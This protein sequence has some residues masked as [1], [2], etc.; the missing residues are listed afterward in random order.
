M[1]RTDLRIC[2][3]EVRVMTTRSMLICPRNIVTYY[4]D[5]IRNEERAKKIVQAQRARKNR[6]IPLVAEEVAK[7]EYVLIENF[8]YYSALLKAQPEVRVPCLVY[9]GTCEEERLIHIL[10]ISIPLDK[11]T[12]WLFKNEHVMKLKQDHELSEREI[13]R[14]AKFNTATINQYILDTRIPPHI[15]EKAFEM[16]AK[17][18]LEKICS[19]K[20]VPLEVKMIL[21]E[22][23]IIEQGND[24]R[25]TGKKFDYMKV[26]CSACNLPPSLLKDTTELESLINKLLSSNFE[27]SDHRVSLLNKFV[28]YDT[29]AYQS[30]QEM[31]EEISVH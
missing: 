9:P 13:A 29:T 14:K 5:E 1:R 2:L 26:F 20:V 15:R 3:T 21:Y 28:V 8:T 25:L 12:S 11:G 18:V 16:D 4:H 27:I 17:S 24:Y 19:S 23:A 10:K 22:K 31:F 7:G 6:I 30:K